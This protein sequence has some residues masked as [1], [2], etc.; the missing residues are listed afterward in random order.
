[1]GSGSERWAAFLLLAALIALSAIVVWVND[2]AARLVLSLIAVSVA[3][4]SAVTPLAPRRGP[5]SGKDR[6]RHLRLR[7]RT[8]ELLTYIRQMN[9]VAAQ[10]R[11]GRR[12][13]SQAEEELN[14]MEQQVHLLVPEI[15]RAVGR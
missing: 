6:R 11:I 5:P 1:M 10:A 2:A 12:P 9:L 15:R 3:I 13:P 7:A 14:E 4:W 8:D